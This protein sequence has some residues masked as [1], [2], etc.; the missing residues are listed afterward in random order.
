MAAKPPAAKVLTPAAV[1]RS[2]ATHK[3]AFDKCVEAG[4]A[5]PGGQALAGR[6]IGLL[7]AIGNN[8]KVEASEVEEADVEG[9]SLGACLRKVAERLTFP[10]FEGETVGIRVPMALSASGT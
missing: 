6:K 3:A 8:G 1:Q 7:I 2:F 5:G 4:L 10:A 9:S